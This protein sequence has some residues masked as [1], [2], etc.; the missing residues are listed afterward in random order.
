MNEGSEPSKQDIQK[1]LSDKT[2]LSNVTEEQIA[3]AYSSGCE[4]SLQ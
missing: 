1:I 2:Y 3:E 4:V